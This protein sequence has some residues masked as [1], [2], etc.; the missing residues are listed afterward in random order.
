MDGINNTAIL[1][2]LPHWLISN[3]IQF[4]D[5]VALVTCARDGTKVL[6]TSATQARLPMMD[7]NL[8]TRILC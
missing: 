3:N 7:S 8:E 1:T 2:P 4:L 6:P 5:L